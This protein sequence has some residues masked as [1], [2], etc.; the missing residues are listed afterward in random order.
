MLVVHSCPWEGLNTTLVL[1]VREPSSE[2]GEMLLSA[3]CH[4]SPGDGDHGKTAQPPEFN[5]PWDFVQGSMSPL[6][7][8][9]TE[10]CLSHSIRKKAESRSERRPSCLVKQEL[11]EL[12]CLSSSVVHRVATSLRV[13]Q[14][15]HRVAY[16]RYTL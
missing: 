8:F 3:H 1:S 15:F 9:G 14:A 4:A 11:S 2:E 13:V 16:Q 12:C 7:R 6:L 5:K 10:R